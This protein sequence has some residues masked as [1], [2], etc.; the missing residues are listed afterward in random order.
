MV[1]PGVAFGF[2]NLGGRNVPLPGQYLRSE[3]DPACWI[4]D[5]TGAVICAR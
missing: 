4:N 1:R 2:V 3:T 5:S